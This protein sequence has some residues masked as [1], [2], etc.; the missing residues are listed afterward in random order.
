MLLA[1]VIATG[2]GRGAGAQATLSLT[3]TSKYV[4][5][6]RWDWTVYV[7]GSTAAIGQIKCVEYTLHPTFLKPVRTVC[8]RGKSTQPFALSA[9]GWGEFMINSRVILKDGSKRP[10]KYWLTLS[11][12]T[13]TGTQKGTA[14]VA[15]M[16]A[17]KSGCTAL[18]TMTSR[19][20][21][22]L[23]VTE[24]PAPILVY[25]EEIHGKGESHFYIMKTARGSGIVGDKRSEKEVLG[26]L[27][28][29]GVRKASGALDGETYRTLSVVAGHPAT[30]AATGQTVVMTTANPT[31]HG[32]VDLTFCVEAPAK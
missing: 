25:T 10:L 16:G 2:V 1:G 21:S 15:Q 19:E 6:G 8:D 28:K 12:P 23:A 18:I 32:S 9:N 5:D 14:T 29:M 24:G 27:D 4:G 31:E 17:T 11:E 13:A 26:W 22:V 7:R 30:I 20:A 3:N